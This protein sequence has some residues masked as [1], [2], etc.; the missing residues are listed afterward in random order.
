MRAG[1]QVRLGHFNDAE[2]RAAERRI[3]TENHAVGG[4]SRC[5]SGGWRGRGGARFAPVHARGHFIELLQ[6]D[7]HSGT[8]PTKLRAQKEKTALAT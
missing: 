4:R 6:G 7:T 8:V 2:T 3:K 1:D 5:C